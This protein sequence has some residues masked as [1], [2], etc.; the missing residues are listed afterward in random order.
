MQQVEGHLSGLE[1]LGV[2]RNHIF[3][4][5]DLSQILVELPICSLILR[6]IFRTLTE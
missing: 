4:I 6:N 3:Q 1:P 5:L 2:S